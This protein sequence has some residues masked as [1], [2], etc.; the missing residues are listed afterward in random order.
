MARRRGV[1]N[2]RIWYGDREKQALIARNWSHKFV[3]GDECWVCLDYKRQ[4]VGPFK[5][6]YYTA[7]GALLLWADPEVVCRRAYRVEFL[8]GGRIF[9]TE[10]EANLA[11]AIE[12]LFER[13]RLETQINNLNDRIESLVGQRL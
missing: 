1:K 5:F 9:P 3:E 4:I 12:L 2:L 10:K 7:C 8:K 6:V 11:T 13:S